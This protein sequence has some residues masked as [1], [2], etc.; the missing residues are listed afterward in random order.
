MF[1]NMLFR[2]RVEDWNQNG[3][4]VM[5][6]KGMIIMIMNIMIEMIGMMMMMKTI[7]GG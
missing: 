7:G 4:H 1:K 3:D 6:G 2:L 5:I